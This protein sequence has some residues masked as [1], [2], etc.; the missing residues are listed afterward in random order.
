MLW[1]HLMRISTLIELHLLQIRLSLEKISKPHLKKRCK[2]YNQDWSWPIL[3]AGCKCPQGHKIH[4]Y[5]AALSSLSVI[6][7]SELELSS[8]LKTCSHRLRFSSLDAGDL[9][10]WRVN[11]LQHMCIY[12]STYG[13]FFIQHIDFLCFTMI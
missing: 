13:W 8:S 7:Q 6:I 9:S 4:I 3:C 1:K 5:I 12:C 2:K 11:L 10:D